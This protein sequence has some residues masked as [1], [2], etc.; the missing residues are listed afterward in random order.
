MGE[1]EGNTQLRKNVAHW[2]TEVY[3]SGSPGLGKG[4][5]GRSG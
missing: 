1:A 2:L 5:D 4:Y 3:F